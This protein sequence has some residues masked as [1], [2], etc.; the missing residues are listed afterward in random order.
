LIFAKI[1]FD[2]SRPYAPM[3]VFARH[4]DHEERH[5]TVSG[6][7]LG[8]ATIM[9]GL[10]CVAFSSRP[11]VFGEYTYLSSPQPEAVLS[12]Q[13]RKSDETFRGKGNS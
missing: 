6:A 13:Q 2:I 7:A 5:I 9:A 8:Y 11:H 12:N 1:L 4:L 10:R 3:P